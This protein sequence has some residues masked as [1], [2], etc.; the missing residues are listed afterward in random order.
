MSWWYLH[1]STRQY[2]QFMQ[3]PCHP[4]QDD[5]GKLFKQTFHG[6]RS[7][8]YGSDCPAQ[9]N[10]VLAARWQDWRKRGQYQSENICEHQNSASPFQRGSIFLNF[11]LHFSA[12]KSVPILILRTSWLNSRTSWFGLFWF[13]KR[14]G[15]CVHFSSVRI[16]P[17]QISRHGKTFP[18]NP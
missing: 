12:N 8:I 9:L 18:N 13:Y 1:Q 7:Y 6:F 3:Q 5:T 17:D 15:Q 2:L 11:T 10:D 16:D 14:L 4:H